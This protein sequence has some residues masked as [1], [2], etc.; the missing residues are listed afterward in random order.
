VRLIPGERFR[1]IGP[2]V[3]IALR[4]WSVPPTV[5]KQNLL[6]FFLRI[7]GRIFL[8]LHMKVPHGP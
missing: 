5:R 8:K 2:L 7:T 6:S 3:Q 1:P 4:L